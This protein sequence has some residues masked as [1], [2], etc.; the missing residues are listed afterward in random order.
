MALL[1]VLILVS[2]F[3]LVSCIPYDDD[4][5][6]MPMFGSKTYFKFDNSDKSKIY[7]VSIHVDATSGAELSNIFITATFP[8]EVNIGKVYGYIWSGIDRTDTGGALI[9]TQNNVVSYSFS[10]HIKAVDEIVC[11]INMNSMNNKWSKPI[12]VEISLEFK[13]IIQCSS[14]GMKDG[15]YTKKSTL[16]INPKAWEHNYEGRVEGN[17]VYVEK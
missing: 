11:G 13:Q 15:K 3:S 9:K 14:G 17:W 2:I 6:R 1:R 5:C 4:T 10:R 8:K 7:G 16:S 12:E